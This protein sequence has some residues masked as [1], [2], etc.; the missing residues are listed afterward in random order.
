MEA[1]NGN[2]QM[3]H[4]HYLLTFEAERQND[5][6]LLAKEA[7]TTKDEVTGI[8]PRKSHRS[9]MRSKS[10]IPMSKYVVS[11]SSEEISS[12][13]REDECN[14]MEKAV[15]S[16]EL[17]ML[18]KEATK[19]LDKGS[20]E[21]EDLALKFDA[22]SAR[23]RE[24]EAVLELELTRTDVELGRSGRYDEID[25]LAEVESEVVADI[26]DPANIP[27]TP[28]ELAVATDKTSDPPTEEIKR[29]RK[30]NSEQ[31]RTLS[32]TR[33]SVA[34]IQQVLNKIEYERR[35][36]SMLIALALYFKIEVDSE[37][38]LNEAYVELLKE[39]AR[40]E[41]E[42]HIE[43][44]IAFYGGELAR[45]DN[46]FWKFV[47]ECGKDFDVENAKAEN[48]LFTKDEEEIVGE[49]PIPRSEELSSEED[50]EEV[51]NLIPRWRKQREQE[52]W[53]TDSPFIISSRISF[54]VSVRLL[55][56]LLAL[57]YTIAAILKRN[58]HAFFDDKVCVKIDLLEQLNRH[59]VQVL[60]HIVIAG[61]KALR[62]LL[63][64]GYFVL[65]LMP[66][67]TAVALLYGQHQQQTVH[68]IM[69]CGSENIAMIFNMGAGYCDVCVTAT[70]GGVSHIKAL[71][72]SHIGGEDIIQNIMH[73]LL[74][75]MDSLFLSHGNNEMKTMGLLRVAAHDAVIKLST[76]DIVMID[77]DLENG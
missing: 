76:Q 70:T 17:S 2:Y 57:G 8:R 6:R 4:F 38:G 52:E 23:I 29:L 64:E 46:E 61:G 53:V 20:Q 31:E 19:C 62:Q 58:N 72:G 35:C 56:G 66:E 32:R 65:R 15:N 26:A 71:S 13:G 28:T 16:I 10:R 9:S 44:V 51:K 12:S 60:S 36:Q 25:F 30:M 74:L 27:V 68:D 40:T 24:I 18:L 54:E 41:H 63:K 49:K 69:G 67:P 21:F 1:G 5:L 37:R 33:D 73:H 75:N 34:R 3:A 22:Q 11:S 77:V 59:Y 47:M 7:I 43:S 42:H 55:G 39:R 14:A 48:I 50:E 45:V